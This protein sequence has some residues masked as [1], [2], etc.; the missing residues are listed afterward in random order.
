MGKGKL[1]GQASHASVSGYISV[2]RKNPAIAKAWVEEGQKKIVLK[3]NDD[4]ML[5]DYFEL[6]KKEGIPCELI[7]DA[8]K[9]Q[10][11]PGTATCFAAGP[12]DENE[13]DKILGKLKLL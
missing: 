10:L 9:T 5:L 4:I 13:I 2:S 3:I 7:H 8:G 11:E 12:W 6:C 1:A